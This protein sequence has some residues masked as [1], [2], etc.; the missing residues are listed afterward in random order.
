MTPFFSLQPA[1]VQAGYELAACTLLPTAH[2]HIP[3]FQPT[4][5]SNTRSPLIC[6]KARAISYNPVFS[7]E[8][9]GNYAHNQRIKGCFGGFL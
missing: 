9:T 5:T 7:D 8:L 4:Q 2:L 6:A 3:A 1:G